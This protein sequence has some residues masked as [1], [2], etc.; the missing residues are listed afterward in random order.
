[1]YV[2]YKSLTKNLKFVCVRSFSQCLNQYASIN[3][4][5]IQTHTSKKKFNHSSLF[6]ATWLDIDNLSFL[7]IFPISHGIKQSI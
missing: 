1:M 5:H 6:N 4:F 3:N 2:L 7:P